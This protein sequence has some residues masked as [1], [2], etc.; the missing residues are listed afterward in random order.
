M[1]EIETS[2]AQF[3]SLIT[4]TG[5]EKLRPQGEGAGV[6]TVEL[7][8][9]A[10]GDGAGNP[11]EPSEDMTS[12]VNEQWRGGISELEDDPDNP[13]F[14]VVEAVIPFSEGG[15]F[16]R[17]I[18]IYDT[19]G[20][21]F[22]I[23]NMP[24]EYK[25]AQHEGALRDLV[26]RFYI[27]LSNASNVSLNINP[28][29]VVATRA[30]VVDVAI[31]NALTILDEK[32]DEA[33]GHADRAETARDGAF[34]NADVYDDVP[35]GLASGDAQFQVVEGEEI[36][37]YRRIDASNAEEV[38]R[39][40]AATQNVSE[41]WRAAIDAGIGVERRI[42][43]NPHS[44]T[45]S[46]AGG[47]PKNRPPLSIAGGSS[48]STGT[49][50]VMQVPSI[51]ARREMINVLANPAVMLVNILTGNPAS[52]SEEWDGEYRAG[53]AWYSNRRNSL[54][55]EPIS[56]YKIDASVSQTNFYEDSFTFGPEGSGADIE[57][58]ADAV[59]AIPF[60]EVTGTTG[61]FFASR[62]EVRD[63]S[64]D[65]KFVNLDESILSF[66]RQAVSG[67]SIINLFRD[68]SDG[69]VFD[70]T[71]PAAYKAPPVIGGKFEGA[72]SLV[73]HREVRTT[74][75]RE[76]IIRARDGRLVVS[77]PTDST[78][79]QTLIADDALLMQ[80]PCTLIFS[81]LA[82]Q[83]DSGSLSV[84]WQ[85]ST[86]AE[87]RIQISLNGRYTGTA[88]V[89]EYDRLQV[90]VGDAE[91]G[92][93]TSGQPLQAETPRG[94]G[95]VGAL[96]LKP[97]ERESEFWANGR[98][99]DKFTAPGTINQ[100][101]SYLMG[102]PS[103]SSAPSGFN[104]GRL[105]TINRALDSNELDLACNWAGDA[106][107]K[108]SWRNRPLNNRR[109]LQATGAISLLVPTS[110]EPEQEGYYETVKT[111]YEK[112][113]DEVLKPASVT[114]VMTS[115]LMLDHVNDLQETMMMHDGD[116]T[117][118][119]GN[120]LSVGDII[121]YYDAL[122]NMLLP[123]SN[124]TTKVVARTIGQKILDD[125]GG[126]GDPVARFT[127]AMND[128]AKRLGMHSTHFTN[129]SGLNSNEMVSTARDLA[130]MG[131]SALA[132]RDIVEIWSKPSYS[133]QIQGDN[134]RSIDISHSVKI[135]NDDDVI[136]GKTGTLGSLARNLLLLSKMPNGNFAVSVV[137]LQGD[138]ERY[139]DMRAMLE[140][141][142]ANYRWPSS[143]LLTA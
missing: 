28:S 121:T 18:G 9:M 106:F 33:S 62:L 128:K 136:G 60:F 55:E 122:H 57:A 54:S 6:P 15:W 79:R 112:G 10:V 132:Y 46:L 126:S 34:V 90:F 110:G 125:E 111:L 82:E 74:A 63:I 14:K 119:S 83:V 49:T 102:H 31:P 134:A 99:V 37:R 117:G 53:V 85:H 107:G 96:V 66:S 133:V 88:I 56:I 26:I 17:E 72:V 103:L 61:R 143:Y 42:G 35:T 138:D 24:P 75:D 59:Y 22:A 140:Y 51:V 8:K 36:V 20:D 2:T 120:N 94:M 16:V 40:P 65:Q 137:L 50:Y 48:G 80:M 21:L 114:K 84:F 115:M 108:N 73:G 4:A 81:V 69:S 64:L 41:G 78:E 43:D 1:A 13:T 109:L 98:L 139:E 5:L 67:S 76:V 91:G 113:A 141:V 27:E 116:Q 104:Y 70:F 29:H 92:Q 44:Y 135:I 129:A 32:V 124:V 123:S 45:Q 93:G 95:V 142:K 118:G 11:V 89:T 12:L 87:G 100:T 30:W 97:G 101:N 38:A 58:P 23:G 77:Q 127:Q 52:S 7:A 3:F 68:G 71:S 105:L 47:S 130:R 86:G 25:P 39:Y 19:D 131:V